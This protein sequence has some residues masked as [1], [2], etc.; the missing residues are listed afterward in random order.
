M[1]KYHTPKGISPHPYQLLLSHPFVAEDRVK[2]ELGG[3]GQDGITK[4]VNKSLK[5]PC[6]TLR[7]WQRQQPRNTRNVCPWAAPWLVPESLGRSAIWGW[8]VAPSLFSDGG[9]HT[10]GL[11]ILSRWQPGHRARPRQWLHQA[12]SNPEP[13]QWGGDPH[14]VWAVMMDRAKWQQSSSGNLL[15]TRNRA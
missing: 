7:G 5:R 3:G 12:I 4:Q 1:V 2:E 10:P 9:H 8:A 11:R 14:P 6:G 15:N 13:G